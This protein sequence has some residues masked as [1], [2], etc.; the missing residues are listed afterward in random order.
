MSELENE[1][2]KSV[3][4]LKKGKVL[5]YPTDT[6][7]GIGCDATQPKAIQKIYKIKERQESKR[8][9]L[10]LDE[11]NKLDEYV[12]SVPAL[13]YD[14]IENA[15]SPITIVYPGAKNLP[16][17]LLAEDGSIAIRIVNGDYCKEVI[18]RLGKPLVSTS[19]NA[20]GEP[21][22]KTFEQ[23][24]E[25]I[26]QKVDYV[27]NIHRGRIREVKPSTLVK[28]DASGGFTILRS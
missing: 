23:I 26:K 1:V 7:W 12:K 21:S 9:I 25:T 3:E 10:L 14:L 18:K 17:I 4:L 24:T 22:P 2:V 16:K 19:A 8:L 13:A 27:V 15:T 28:L 6:I 5:L 11:I 20:S